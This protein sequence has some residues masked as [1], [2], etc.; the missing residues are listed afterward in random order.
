MFKSL[1]SKFLLLLISVVAIGLSAT[2]LLRELMVKDFRE[3]L[4]GEREDKAYWVTAALESS[5]DT[6]TGWREESIIENTVWAMMLGIEMKLF[7][8]EGNL[9]MDTDK[10]I[11]T[12]SPFVKKR[13]MAISERRAWED[14]GPFTPYDSFSRRRADRPYRGEVPVPSERERSLSAGPTDFF[15]YRC[16][17][18]EALQYS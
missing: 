13:V 9:V 17:P 7:D 2:F 4:E 15:L 12:L 16:W 14:N 5:Y 6:Y 3:Y 1:W 8:A 11:D 18:W 10:A